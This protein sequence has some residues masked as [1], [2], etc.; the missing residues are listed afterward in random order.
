M[1]DEDRVYYHRRA[2]REMELAREARHPN[3]VRA[4]AQLASYYADLVENE[5]A[6]SFRE[7]RPRLNLFARSR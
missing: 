3:A 7:E 2:Q 5:N 1:K 6:R 4:H